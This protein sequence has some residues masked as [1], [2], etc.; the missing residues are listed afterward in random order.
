[1]RRLVSAVLMLGVVTCPPKTGN[2]MNS[3]EL[4]L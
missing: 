1:M 2:F 3:P 4:A